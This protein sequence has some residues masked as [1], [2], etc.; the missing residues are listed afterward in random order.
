MYSTP[1]RDMRIMCRTTG[2][3]SV[4]STPAAKRSSGELC[5][6]IRYGMTYMVLPAEAPFIRS[7]WIRVISAEGFQLLYVPLSLS[8]EV[9]TTVRS[10]ERAVSLK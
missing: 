8:D 1:T 10:S 9:A 4:S 3:Q 6:D 5:C 2:R 7:R